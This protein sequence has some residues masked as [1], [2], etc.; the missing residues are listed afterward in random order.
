[1]EWTAPVSTALGALIGLG[2]SFLVD[3]QRWRRDRELHKRSDLRSAYAAFLQATAEASEILWNIS[4]GYD[5]DETAQA[6]AR[7]VLRDSSVLSR[8]F[9]LSLVASDMMADATSAL[10]KLLIGYRDAVGQGLSHDDEEVRRPRKEFNRER[11]RLIRVMR[12]TL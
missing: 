5:S 6:R 1:M 7:T 11:E 2:S 10:I 9:E 3:R 4:V 8:Q 12:E